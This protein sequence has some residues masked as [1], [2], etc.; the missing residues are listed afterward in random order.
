LAP[1][2]KEQKEEKVEF[3]IEELEE[4]VIC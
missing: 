1:K 2:S 4:K 3:G